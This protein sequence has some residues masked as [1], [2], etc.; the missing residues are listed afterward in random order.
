MTSTIPTF[1]YISDYLNYWAGNMPEAEAVVI[2]DR[3]LSYAE[4]EAAVNQCA[5]AL[6]AAGV[7]KGD[8]VATLSAPNA[9]YFITFL[10]STTIGAIWVGLNPRY[11]TSELAYVVGDAQPAV[12][13]APSVIDGHSCQAEVDG[14][15]E[16][17]NCLKRIVCTD[18]ADFDAFLQ[19]TVDTD[20]LVS[21]RS[22]RSPEDAAVLVYTSGSTGSPKGAIL[23]QQAIAAFSRRQID[24]W[25]VSP[26]RVLNYFPINH[27]GCL[28][29][30][31]TPCLAA[32]GL[33]VLLEEFDPETALALMAREKI[34]I[35]GSVPSV[36]TMQLSLPNFDRY[37]LSSVQLIV[38]GGAAMPLETIKRLKSVCPR[39]ATNYG[40]SETTSA[41]TFVAPTDSEEVLANSV[42]FPFHG[43]TLRLT[44]EAGSVVAEGEVGEIETV[45]EYVTLGYW[46]RPEATRTAFSADGWFKTGDLAVR[47]PDGRYR[48]V[49]RCKE[50]YKSGGYNVYPREI[51]N[52]LEQHPA[53]TAA[54]VVSIPDPLWQEV[55]VAYV[56][57]QTDTA[58]EELIGYC[59]T[60]LANYKIPKHIV[61]VD[62]MPL[63][64]IGKID[65]V[66][67][68][69]RAEAEFTA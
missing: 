44:N 47:R 30:V 54:A 5:N 42:G 9:V 51:E 4:L 38:W 43:V 16:A 58:A 12:I 49:G 68:R 26:M 69:K 15:R 56:A 59:R 41:M 23:S 8:R 11:Q 24:A 64:P 18:P 20:T 36:F 33:M 40:M 52:V 46:N 62:A 55:G 35:W 22:M 32:G 53:I 1:P 39:L 48:I 29:D 21:V 10:A 2:N 67:L 66:S 6:L 17:A 7:K 28:I 3:R 63:L 13:F 31:S 25:P 65:K 50:M 45:S 57:T 60:Q 34:T 27:V 61:Q 14:M 37:D 19:S